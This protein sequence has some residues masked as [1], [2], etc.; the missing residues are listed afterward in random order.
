MACLTL[1]ACGGALIG[2]GVPRDGL[3]SFAPVAPAVLAHL[4]AFG[5]VSRCSCPDR[6]PESCGVSGYC[7]PQPDC[8]L[9]CADEGDSDHVR[10]FPVPP[11]LAG[12]SPW[13]AVRRHPRPWKRERS[14]DAVRHGSASFNDGQYLD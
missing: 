1:G 14:E 2:I 5:S 7:R 12:P 8:Y 6:S 3:D 4:W 13:L 9:L 11:P 10:L